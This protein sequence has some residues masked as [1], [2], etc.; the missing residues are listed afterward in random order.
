MAYDRGRQRVVLFG[1]YERTPDARVRLGDTWEWDGTGWTL[2]STTGPAPRNGAVM[3]YDERLGRVVFV[4]LTESV[5]E[6]VGKFV[7]YALFPDSVYSVVVGLLKNGPKISVG[8]NPWSGRP[9]D[10]DISAICARYGGGGHPVVG[11]ISFP[12]AALDEARR[13]A[14]SIAYELNGDVAAA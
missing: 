2:A 8:Y 9:L 4:D 5:L 10:T 11:G 1:G 12:T 3:A 14:R 13:V 7:T 6:S